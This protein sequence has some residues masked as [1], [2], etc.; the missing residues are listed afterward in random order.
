[1]KQ[2]YDKMTNLNLI[3]SIEAAELRTVGRLISETALRALVTLV[4]IT[5]RIWINCAN[6]GQIKLMLLYKVV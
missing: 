1:M 3:R 5:S 4:Q 2:Y 6:W